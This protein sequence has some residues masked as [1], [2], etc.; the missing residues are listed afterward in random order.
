MYYELSEIK[1]IRKKHNLTQSQLAKIADV[2]Q[3]LIAK[4]EASTIDPTYSKA[5]KI[6]EALYRLEN[7]SQPTAEKIM[8][9]HLLFCHGNDSL[10][11]TIEKMKKFSIS[12]LPVVENNLP[13][14]LISEAVA[15]DA[16]LTHKSA[17]VKIKEIMI[18]S[19]P[20]IG[21]NASL[22]LISQL[23]NT[24]PLL[25]VSEKGKMLGIITKVDILTNV[26]K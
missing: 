23:L 8:N 12:Q 10:K 18:D 11:E 22:Q 9:K 19:P 7:Q 13:I 26:Y 15:L 5:M 3:S 2:S 21:K 4:I 24:Y 17:A 16:L 6:F 25:I 14:G 20:I 1:T